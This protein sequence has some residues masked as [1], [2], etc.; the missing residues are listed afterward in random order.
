[1]IQAKDGLAKSGAFR[2]QIS[3]VQQKSRLLQTTLEYARIAFFNTLLES[4]PIR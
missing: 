1:M 3:G 4:A 2:G